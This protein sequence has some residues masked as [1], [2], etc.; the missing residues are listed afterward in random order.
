MGFKLSIVTV[1]LNCVAAIRPTIE[2]VFNQSFEGIESIVVDGGSTDGTLQYL[3]ANRA[4]I[5]KLISEKDK[6]IYDAMNKGIKA[7]T[8]DYILFVNAGDRL[9]SADVVRR[10]MTDP[11]IVALRPGIISGKIQFE[12]DGV[13]WNQYSS[14][15][16]QVEGFGLPHQATFLDIKLHQE[17]LFDDRYRFVGDHELWRRLEAKGLFHIM[18]VDDVVSVFALGGASNNPKNDM[19]RFL[20]RAYVD[21]LYSNR[22]GVREWSILFVK[23]MARRILHSLFGE[24]LYFRLLRL[25]W[26]L[27]PKKANP[28]HLRELPTPRGARH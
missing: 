26:E 1:C 12:H 17:N 16:G 13:V 9:A 25:R 2:S 28:Q 21:Y 18:Y 10:I 15:E 6:G 24:K 22:F 11:E 7:A 3:E 14:G 4:R 27:L 20:E 8:G 5:T 23:P 19:K